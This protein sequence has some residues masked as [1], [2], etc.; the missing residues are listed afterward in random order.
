MTVRKLA[1]NCADGVDAAHLRHL[2]VH[3]GDVRMMPSKL[4][5]RLQ[6]ITGFRNQFH[7]YLMPDQR[8]DAG[9]EKGMV[10]YGQY[11]NHSSSCFLPEQTEKRAAR[12][13]TICNRAS[14]AQIGRVPAALEDS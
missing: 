6:S 5:D 11:S 12:R 14:D 2:Q 4:F 3:Q 1:A 13:R 10:V 9:A 8:G 7:V